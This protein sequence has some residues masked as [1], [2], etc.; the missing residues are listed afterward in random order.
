MSRRTM[1]FSLSNSS[2]AN[3]FANSVFPTPVGPKKIK[4]PLQQRQKKIHHNTKQVEPPSAH[5]YHGLDSSARPARDR[6]TASVTAW[7]ARG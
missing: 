6:M 3:A 4:L 7:T 5:I 1:F 2:A